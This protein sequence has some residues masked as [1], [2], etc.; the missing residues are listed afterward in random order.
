MGYVMA[1][2]DFCQTMVCSHIVAVSNGPLTSIVKISV[3]WQLSQRGL[4]AILLSGIINTT[5]KH[6]Y[7]PYR[8]RWR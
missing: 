7:Y 5:G 4:H 2:Y 8:R 6:W 1:H 3:C